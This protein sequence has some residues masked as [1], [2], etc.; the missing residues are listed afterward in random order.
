MRLYTSGTFDLFHAGHAHFLKR[1]QDIVQYRGTVTVALNT[2]AF[3][4]RYKGKPPVCSYEERANVLMSC[5]YVDKVVPN[6]HGED[7]KDTIL[8]VKPAYLAVGSDW[9]TKDYYKQMG[10]TQDWLDAQNI[11]LIYIPYTKGVSTSE[12]KTRL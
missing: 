5:R 9:A 8:K 6:E 7:S 10:F 1:C 2:D 11:V 4:E 12:I 3:V